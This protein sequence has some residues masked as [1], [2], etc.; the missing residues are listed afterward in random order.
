M[1]RDVTL[2]SSASETAY[3]VADILKRRGQLASEDN[4]PIYEFFTTGEDVEEFRRF[5]GRVFNTHLERVSH[6]DLPEL[7]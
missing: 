5:G 1:G 7:S 4:E 3:D 2:I 6:V